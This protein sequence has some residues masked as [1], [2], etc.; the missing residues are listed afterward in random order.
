MKLPV[1]QGGRFVRFCK[2]VSDFLESKTYRFFLKPLLFVI[3]T[4]V[5]IAILADSDLL[6]SLE[7]ILGAG[8]I[9]IIKSSQLLI[10]ISAFT[11]MHLGS[12]AEN[13]ISQCGNPSS[14]LNREDFHSI[15]AT[16]NEVVSAKMAR[17]LKATKTALSENWSKDRIFSEITQP[18]Q[19]IALLVKAV[20]GLFEYLSKNKV[21]FRVGLIKIDKGK[22]S[23]FFCFQPEEHPPKTK[24]STLGAPTSSVMRAIQNGNMV[25][26]SDIQKELKKKNKDE[27]NFVKGNKKPADD[28]SILTYPIYCPNTKEPI[29]V[30][31][32]L[33]KEKNSIDEN[34]KELYEW[35]LDHFLPRII[36]EHHLLIMKR[37]Q[38][39]VI[40]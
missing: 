23:E 30:L 20:H 4:S 38:H 26:V 11:L 22:P 12:A 14:E 24:I 16:I 28:G 32:I 7:K 31:S 6:S 10:V 3:P 15:L 19:Q 39:D 34:N 9:S 8:P 1:S 18:D 40:R 17:F 37:R 35:L 5:M 25:L 33:G 21:N 2:I 36:I 13:F 29:Y 27:R